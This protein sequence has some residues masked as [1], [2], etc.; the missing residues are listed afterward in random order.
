M[1]NRENSNRTVAVL[2]RPCEGCRPLSD[3]AQGAGFSVCE[4]DDVDQLIAAF[5]GQE[6]Y[7]GLIA[8][9]ALWP[10]PQETARRLRQQT[11]AARLI[12]CFADG[13]PRQNLGRRMWAVD[14]IDHFIPRSIAPHEMAPIVRQ[15]YADALIESSTTVEAASDSEGEVSLRILRDLSQGFSNQRRLESLLRFLHHRLPRVFDYRLLQVLVTE[16][17]S[18]RLYSFPTFRI[19]HE[20]TWALAEKVCGTTRSLAE[21][22]IAVEQTEIVETPP[23]S[24]QDRD[25][26]GDNSLE[27]LRIA[28]PLVVHGELVGGLGLHLSRHTQLPRAEVSLLHLIATQLAAA[29]RNTQALRAAEDSS[30]ID[31]LTGL[32]NRRFLA[33]VLKSEWRRVVRSKQPLTVAMLDLDHFKQL[34]D[35]HGH[36][37]GDAVLSGF[38]ALVTQSL[39]STDHAIRYG[40]EEFLAILP[41]TGAAEAALVIERIRL[42]LRMRPIYSTAEVGNIQLSFSAGIAAYPICAVQEAEDLVNLADQA[43]LTAKSN[44]RDQVC[45]ASADSFE[46]VDINGIISDDQQERRR[47]PRVRSEL[48]VRYVALPDLQGQMAAARSIDFSGSGLAVTDPHR[49]L[50]KHSY[51]LVFVEDA[52]GPVLSQ[53][54]WTRDSADGRRSAGLRFLQHAELTAD[55]DSVSGPPSALVVTENE[56]LRHMVKRVLTAARY[57]LRFLDRRKDLSEVGPLEQYSLIL[58]GHSSMRGWFG[59]QLEQIHRDLPSSSRMVVINEGGDRTQALHTINEGQIQHFVPFQEGSD[60][61]L[62][63]TLNKLLLGEYFGMQKYL[64][65]GV[66]PRSWVVQGKSDKETALCGIR[67]IAEEVHCHPRIADL[68]V[69][70]VEE[71]L[72]NAMY[73]LRDE[74]SEGPSSVTLECGTD[75]RQLAVAVID[76]H[77]L[78]RNDN[79]FRAVGAALQHEREG[80]PEGRSTAS[81]GFRIM[82]L[83]LS[84]LV[85]NVSPGR[86]T[87]IIGIVDLRQSLAEY[88][89]TAPTLGLFSKV[90]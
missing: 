24:A 88:R 70:A 80:L 36:I 6:H 5:K 53:V 76:E 32:Q 78:F 48:N 59:S 13:S 16:G 20:E 81:L 22:D 17:E 90:D 57:N 10:N 19:T 74:S 26:E 65:W 86:C 77:G 18:K 12:V 55:A 30:L 87:E 58:V 75:G 8:Y 9:E 64:Q 38:A 72:I 46:N 31:E 82:L 41:D 40:G 61:V 1:S 23:L 56:R 44:G 52:Q 45:M 29:I 50:K 28:L 67:E 63:A 49:R 7:V 21:H 25:S 42:A 62:F 51:A 83:C 27:T 60:Q 4:V 66:H 35:R 89:R 33:R 84:Q 71:M 54:V 2:D 15:A 79:L 37:V 68:L 11:P 39:R 3:T 43:L 73:H 14:L 85:V 69:A 47:F 34:N